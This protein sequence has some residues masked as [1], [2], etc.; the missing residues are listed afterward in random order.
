RFEVGLYYITSSD[1]VRKASD[2]EKYFD[3]VFPHLENP[4]EIHLQILNDIKK[5]FE[6]PFFDALRTYTYRPKS[7]F[8]A[9]P[10][11]RAKSIF[12]S[13]WMQDMVAFYGH[14]IFFAESSAT[15]G[16]LD[17]LLN[18]TGSLRA[19]LIKASKYFG[20]MFTFFVTDGTSASNRIV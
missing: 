1:P 10:I 13:I 4:I 12:K 5:R 11:S 20:S 7:T 16:G 19:A 3:L 8:H 9:L 14:R 2:L 17:S 18:P 6:A 15:S